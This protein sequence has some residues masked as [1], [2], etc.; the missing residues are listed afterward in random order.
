MTNAK[1]IEHIFDFLKTE[2][3][4]KKTIIESNDKVIVIYESLENKKRFEMASFFN[5]DIISLKIEPEKP[6][7]ESPVE[8]L[9]YVNSNCDEKPEF[10]GRKSAFKSFIAENIVYPLEALEKGEQG[11]VYLRFTVDSLGSVVE[12][13]IVHG[14]SPSLDKEALRV[15]T[16]MPKWKP[17]RQDGRPVSVSFTSPVIFRNTSKFKNI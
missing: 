2:Y 6:E 17:A 11:V 1:T 10:P 16:L 5:K 3:D 12:P 14:V 13:T 8:I 15:V 7:I 9:C 4:Y